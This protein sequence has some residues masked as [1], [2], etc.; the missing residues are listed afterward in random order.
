M[1]EKIKTALA[2]YG[3]SGQVFHGPLL[4]VNEKFEVVSILERSKSLSRRLF[5]DAKIVRSFDD[6]LNNKAIELLVVNTPDELHYEMVGQAL[7]A[8]K[9]VVAEK[10]VTQ[11]RNQAEELYKQ[12]EK[13]GLLLTV[14]QNRRFDGD[15][16]TVKM[17][18]EQGILGRLIEFES[19]YDRYRNYID[20]NS[21]KEYG[22]QYSG[23][24]YN[25]GSHMIDQVYVLLGKPLAVTAHLK[26]VRQ[27]GK[28]N[29]YYDIRLDYGNFAAVLKCSYLVMNP[30]PR[31]SL[32]GDKGSFHKWGIDPQE[33]Q[34]K[35]GKLPVGPSWGADS[36]N[37]WGH[38]LHEKEGLTFS[39]RLETLHG[40]YNM[41]Y[42]NLYNVLRA[43]EEPFIKP[44]E[45]LAVLEILEACIESN[46][47]RKTVYL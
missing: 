43:K 17:L 1:E 45:V 31:Y 37:N 30:G 29:D 9:H 23:V 7:E 33:E 22:N 6:L 35:K 5:P 19:H 11:K 27:G 40:N 20:V 21:W 2:S 25:L 13:K 15:F 44:G 14:F 12:A 47:Q 46:S 36:E 3:M 8:G 32:H 39:G 28:V 24:L 18:L 16:L 26:I 34:M 42:N 38:L 41:F 4:K 10:P